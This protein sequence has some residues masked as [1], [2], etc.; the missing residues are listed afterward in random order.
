MKKIS[1]LVI[2]LLAFISGCSSGANTGDVPADISPSANV[3]LDDDKAQF[4]VPRILSFESV[5]EYHE[6]IAAAKLEE[7]QLQAFLSNKNYDMNGV[8]TKEDI[9]Q[10]ESMVAS[11]P[12][13]VLKEAELT[14]FEINTDSN[15]MFVR[16]N[17]SSEEMVQFRTLLGDQLTDEELANA[18]NTS[19]FAP[20]RLS[21]ESMQSLYYM[22]SNTRT[23]ATALNYAA[24]AE[25]YLFAVEVFGLS[26]ENADNVVGSVIFDTL[27]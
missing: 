19:D 22:G 16:Y 7:T 20:E 14:V 11:V 23:H 9:L 24:N 10:I 2:L 6:L 15:T 27:S 26:R 12:F 18:F 4:D 8:Q 13:P 3:S 25:G 1:I 5:Q 17:L 21:T